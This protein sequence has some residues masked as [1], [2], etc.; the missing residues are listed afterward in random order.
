MD[1]SEDQFV[2]TARSKDLRKVDEFVNLLSM[3]TVG[4]ITCANS[5]KDDPNLPKTCLKETTF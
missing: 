4:N 5:S 1:E 3:K 2:G